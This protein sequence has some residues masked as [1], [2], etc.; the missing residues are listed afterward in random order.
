LKLKTYTIAQNGALV[1]VTE[2]AT[3]EA[4]Q[5]E[6]V[7]TKGYYYFD[8]D[9]SVLKWIGLAE[10]ATATVTDK[11]VFSAE[12]A[13]AALEADGSD[14]LGFLTSDN[15]GLTN[16]FM[17][18]YSW[19]NTKTD[20]GTND[21]DVI[22]RFTVPANFVGWETNAIVLDY[23]ATPNA[24]VQTSVFAEEN[25]TAI[26]TSAALSTT[27]KNDFTS[28]TIAS[29]ENLSSLVAGSTGIIILKMTVT[30]AASVS[31]SIVRIGDITLNFTRGN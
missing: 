14:N 8:G 19:E 30:D 4:G 25:A 23:A 22:L 7:N 18:F 28:T 11:I 27:D 13:G 17:N 3:P 9:A 5:T 15:A 16:S 20:G 10:K 12:Y 29:D 24:N 21:F 26:A 31:D 1:Y 6:N 2:D